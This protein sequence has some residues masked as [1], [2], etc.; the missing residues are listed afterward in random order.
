MA[1]GYT[2]SHIHQAIATMEN[3]DEIGKTKVLVNIYEPLLRLLKRKLDK[4][5]LKRDAY[6]DLALRYES[7]LLKAKV[8]K[9]NSDKARR[10][11]SE[12]LK[13][14]NTNQVSLQ[15]SRETADLITSVC[16]EK[17]IPRDAFI[18][19]FVLFL[20]AP[21]AVLDAAIPAFNEVDLIEGVYGD[22]AEYFWARPNVIDTI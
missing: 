8:D 11:I 9:P 22:V 3:K 19:R 17:N 1:I 20:T 16:N 15:V 10:Y 14:L 18:N 4:A 7:E 12:A 21:K 13:R 2:H 6:L 5:C